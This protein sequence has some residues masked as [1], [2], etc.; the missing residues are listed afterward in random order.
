[1]E[2]QKHTSEIEEEMR[3]YIMSMKERKILTRDQTDFYILEA[4]RLVEGFPQTML[5][6]HLKSSENTHEAIN[7]AKF[8][9]ISKIF[10]E[11]YHYDIE[12]DGRSISL[13]ME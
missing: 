9:K 13:Y 5:R 3:N 11:L 1:M 7:A 4:E 10:I 12:H 2:E 6:K 8:F